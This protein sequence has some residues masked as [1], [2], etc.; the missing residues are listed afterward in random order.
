MHG[1]ASRGHRTLPRLARARRPAGSI[2]CRGG[3]VKWRL[4]PLLQCCAVGIGEDSSATAT[5]GY[6]LHLDWR[7]WVVRCLIARVGSMFASD[8]TPSAFFYSDGIPDLE[9]SFLIL[10]GCFDH[11]GAHMEA[12][13]R[14]ADSRHERQHLRVVTELDRLPSG[15]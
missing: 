6:W 7:K 1:L 13:T 8:C 11:V 5:P 9:F 3:L 15:S 4:W 14:S 12:L 2:W 10:A